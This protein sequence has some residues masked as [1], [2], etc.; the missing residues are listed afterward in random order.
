MM[1][2]RMLKAFLELAA[3]VMRADRRTKFIA[4]AMSAAQYIVGVDEIED[5]RRAAG[6]YATRMIEKLE[7]SPWGA[8]ERAAFDRVSDMLDAELSR[9]VLFD[10]TIGLPRPERTLAA[11]SEAF[12]LAPPP[13]LSEHQVAELPELAGDIV[14]RPPKRRRRSTRRRG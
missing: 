8:Q 11:S 2:L 5:V 13:P 6:M 1:E 12:P 4:A 9:R 7:A 10:F 14:K 3:E